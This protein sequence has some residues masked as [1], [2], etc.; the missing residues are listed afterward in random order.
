[1]VALDGSECDDGRD[2]DSY[3][4]NNDYLHG[5]GYGGER[6]SGY[7]NGNGDGSG[8]THHYIDGFTER[9]FCLCGFSLCNADFDGERLQPD[10]GHHGECPDGLRGVAVERFRLRQFGNGDAEWRECFRYHYICTLEVGCD[11]WS[12]RQRER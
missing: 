4:N 1:L 11:E 7:R 6:L 5:N 12:E 10:G 2:G 8:T 9:V 3:I